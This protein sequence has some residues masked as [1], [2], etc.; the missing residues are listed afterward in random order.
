LKANDILSEV[1]RPEGVHPDCDLL[2]VA[3]VE[4]HFREQSRPVE[5]GKHVVPMPWPSWNWACRDGGAELGVAR[6]WHTVLAGN[7]GRGKSNIALNIAAS[8]IKS[9]VSVGF[10]S[11][12]M[13][14]EQIRSRLL[15]ILTGRAVSSLQRGEKFRPDAGPQVVK[16][17]TELVGDCSLMVNNDMQAAAPLSQ[18]HDIGRLSRYW[19][20]NR[21]VGVII[22]DYMQLAGA[23]RSDAVAERVTEV[24]RELMRLSHHKKVVT[25]GLSQFNRTT[26]GNYQHSP[27]V[28]GVFGASGIEN[29]AH[30]MLLIDHSRYEPEPGAGAR[31]WLMLR[32]N[33]HG[34]EVDIPIWIDHKTLAVTEADDA[35]VGRWPTNGETSSSS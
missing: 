11:L 4:R 35:E 13:S 18:M 3:S 22:V 32:K 5:I 23:G 6:G 28:Q 2:T 8:A 30:Q 14:V 20:E 25:I 19:I 10:I 31:T 1:K 15:G 21:D 9:G 7:P 27:T 24:S 12:E 16:E 33:R 26:S 29:D 34:P 17:L